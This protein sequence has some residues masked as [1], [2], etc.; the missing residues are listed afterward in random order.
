MNIW[1]IGE[2]LMRQHYLKKI[3]YSNS[4]LEDITDPNYMYER[5]I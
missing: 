1:I 4:N 3:F 5:R 2:G